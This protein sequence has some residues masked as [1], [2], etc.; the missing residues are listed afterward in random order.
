MML[1]PA[2]KKPRRKVVRASV[3]ASCT[4]EVIPEGKRAV[5]TLPMPTPSL[6]LF[7][8]SHWRK[9]QSQKKQWALML[10]AVIGRHK[11]ELLALGKRRLT[12]ERHS[13]GELDFD[14]LVGG[15]KCVLTDNLRK[16]GLFTDD[17]KAGIEFVV[18]NVK[19]AK[20]VASHTVVTIEDIA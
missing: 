18:R 5:I 14:N 1:G 6:N 20:G 17:D 12:I 7:S 4:V 13:A 10:L 15:A 19:L 16:M 2:I 11:L 9:Q 3:R 8:Y